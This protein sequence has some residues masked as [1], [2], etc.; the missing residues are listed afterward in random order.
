[1]KK[2]N[3]RVFLV[4][5]IVHGLYTN[6]VNEN[7]NITEEWLLKIAIAQLRGHISEPFSSRTST[8]PISKKLY[9][10]YRSVL[11]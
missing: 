6:T 2:L 5:R 3:K 4:E 8:I 11:Q 7:S 9:D 1:M 10:H